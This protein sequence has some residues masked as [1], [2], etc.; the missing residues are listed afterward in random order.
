[1]MYQRFVNGNDQEPGKW[2]L[3]DAAEPDDERGTTYTIEEWRRL[4]WLRQRVA[5]GLFGSGDTAAGE[6]EE[7]LAIFSPRERSRLA[8]LRWLRERARLIV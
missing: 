7:T 8:F 5:A 2:R 4:V 6:G 1:M 3:T